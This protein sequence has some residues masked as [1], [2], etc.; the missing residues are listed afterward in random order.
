MPAGFDMCRKNGGRI[1]TKKLKGGKYMH[2][3]FLDGKSYAG[4][5]KTAKKPKVNPL[6]KLIRDTKA[7][8]Y[9]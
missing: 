6:L 9:A 4:E 5:V 8:P 3:C 2:I 7:K 1:R